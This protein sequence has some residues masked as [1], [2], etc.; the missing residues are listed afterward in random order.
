MTKS[1]VPDADRC[2][3]GREHSLLDPCRKFAELAEWFMRRA[4][5]SGLD[6]ARR[7]ALH[8]AADRLFKLTSSK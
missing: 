7:E 8:G 4:G 3:E 1:F 5:D 6:V 2:E